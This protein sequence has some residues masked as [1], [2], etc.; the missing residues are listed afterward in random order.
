MTKTSTAAV[1]TIRNARLADVK[2]ISALVAKVYE[3]MPPYTEGMLRGQP[4]SSAIGL[5]PTTTR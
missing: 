2:A 1:L 5:S 3:D 4:N